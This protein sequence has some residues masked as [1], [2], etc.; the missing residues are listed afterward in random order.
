MARRKAKGAFGATAGTVPQTESI[1][2]SFTYNYESPEDW[3]AQLNSI[4]SPFP[5]V[6]REYD[7]RGMPTDW[8]YKTAIF[9]PNGEELPE[10]ARGWQFNGKPDFGPGLKGIWA[11]ISY[12]FTEDRTELPDDNPALKASLGQVKDVYDYWDTEAEAGN[13]TAGK[14]YGQSFMALL[15][16]AAEGIRAGWEGAESVGGDKLSV[17]NVIPRA[18]GSFVSFIGLGAQE[19]DRWW[20]VDVTGPAY[21]NSIASLQQDKLVTDEEL[22]R[23][24][25]YVGP[26]KAFPVFFKEAIHQ[27][28]GAT[29]LDEVTKDRNEL[30]SELGYTAWKDIAVKEEFL[31]RVAAGEDP[32]LLAMELEDP[33]EEL[34]GEFLFDPLNLISLGAKKLL[35]LAADLGAFGDGVK[36]ARDGKRLMRAIDVAAEGGDVGKIQKATAELLQWIND[37]ARRAVDD[38]AGDARRAEDLGGLR[39]LLTETADSLQNTLTENMSDTIHQLVSLTEGPD[40]AVR[41]MN[42]LSK[43]LD[44]NLEDVARLEALEN[45]QNAIKGTNIPKNLLFGENAQRTA[46]VWRRLMGDNN[47]KRIVELLDEAGGDIVKTNQLLADELKRITNDIFPTIGRRIEEHGKYTE[48][49]KSGKAEDVAKANKILETKPWAANAPNQLHQTLHQIYSKVRPAYRAAGKA[50]GTLFMGLNPA[51]RMRNR[52]GNFAVLFVDVSPK[53]AAESFFENPWS[54]KWAR[55]TLNDYLGGFAP[56]AERR[57]IGGGAAASFDAGDWMKGKFNYFATKASEDE[58]IAGTHVMARSVKRFMNRFL[59]PKY[60]LQGLDQLVKNPGDVKVLQRLIKKHYGDVNKALVEFA[61]A[62]GVDNL[63]N[64]L[65][66]NDRQLAILEKLHLDDAVRK[67]L[68]PSLSRQEQATR[69]NEIVNQHQGRGFLA[70]GEGVIRRDPRYIEEIADIEKGMGG[71]RGNRLGDLFERKV[72]TAQVMVDEASAALDDTLRMVGDAVHNH[73]TRGARSVDEAKSMG[74]KAKDFMFNVIQESKKKADSVMAGETGVRRTMLNFRTQVW[75]WNDEVTEMQ[76][77]SILDL[78][79]KQRGWMGPVPEFAEELPKADLNRM[80]KNS[81]WRG[82]TEKATREYWE[83]F[84]GQMNHYMDGIE[85]FKHVLDPEGTG[86]ISKL[87]EPMLERVRRKHSLADAMHRTVMDGN[88][89]AILRVG[90]N[91]L[92]DLLIDTW[93]IRKAASKALEPEGLEA[94][95]ETVRRFIHNIRTQAQ[96]GTFDPKE[97]MGLL[98]DVLGEAIKD[99]A[100]SEARAEEMLR[101]LAGKEPD[102][103]LTIRLLEEEKTTIFLGGQT[104]DSIKFQMRELQTE[105]NMLNNPAG[106]WGE[107]REGSE[108]LVTGFGDKPLRVSVD[109]LPYT[110][111][112]GQDKIYVNTPLGRRSVKR[113]QISIPDDVAENANRYNELSARMNRM[114]KRLKTAPEQLE[115]VRQ[116][117]IAEIDRRI[118]AIQDGLDV[119]QTA[120]RSAIAE[121]YVKVNEADLPQSMQDEFFFTEDIYRID[122]GDGDYALFQP[123]FKTNKGMGWRPGKFVVPEAQRGRGVGTKFMDEMKKLSDEFKL[124]MGIQPDTKDLHRFYD[125]IDGLI[126]DEA[127]GGRRYLYTPRTDPPERFSTPIIA[128]MDDATPT[129]ARSDYATFPQVKKSIDEVLAHLNTLDDSPQLSPHRAAYSNEEWARLREGASGIQEKINEVRT[130]AGQVAVKERD[131]ALHNYGKRYGFDMVAGLIFPYQFWYSRS[132]AKWM[133]RMVQ[134]PAIL[135]HYLQYR[136]FLEKKHAGLPDWWKYQMNTNDLFGLDAENPLYFNLE[137]MINP[138]HGLTN[139]D[140]TD[141]QRRKDWWGGAMEDIQKMGPSVWT[142]FTYGLAAYYSLQGEEEAAA[143]WAGRLLPQSKAIRDITALVDPQ[144][145]GIEIDPAVHLWGGGDPLAFTGSKV[146]VEAYERGRVGRQLGLMVNEGKWTEAEI[147]EAAYRQEGEIWDVARARAIH[148]RASHWGLI[149]GQFMFGVGAKPRPEGDIQIDTMYKEMR[150]LIAHRPDVSE[151]NYA[152]GWNML[153]EAY[154]FLDT[155]LLAKKGGLERDEALAWNV[156]N[157]IPPGMSFEM[158]K[159]ANMDYDTITQ[160]RSNKGDLSE[161]SEAQRLDFMGGVMQLG[162]LLDVPPDATRRD[163]DRASQEYSDMMAHGEKVFGEDIWQKV[164]LYY[165]SFDESNQDAM[166]NF[167]KANPIVQE[168]LDF[169]QMTINGSPSLMTYYGSVEK[170]EK[171]YKGQ[172]YQT[173]EQVFGDNIWDKWSV[174]HELKDM[175]ETKAANKYFKDNPELKGYL[176]MRDEM[177]PIIDQKVLELGD[178]IE[179]RQ[180]PFFRGEENVIDPNVEIQSFNVDEQQRWISDQVMSY[181]QGQSANNRTQADVVDH[182]RAQA[183]SLWPSTK[184]SARR[185]YKIVNSNP[186]GAASMLQEN[187]ELETRVRW[188]FDR[189]LRIALAREGELEASAARYQSEL[190]QMGVQGQSPTAFENLAPGPLKRLL[191]D[192]DGLPPHL[193]ELLGGR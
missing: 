39:G 130:M 124:E 178:T 180:G 190:E 97:T 161:L 11:R 153:R 107:L 30:A 7:D 189:I 116:A 1:K 175:G 147:I 140:F 78:W 42:D 43:L 23:W 123:Q 26:L 185:Y 101:I 172:F 86:E 36:V 99:V 2:A 120:I 88:G 184:Q 117:E 8:D 41:L 76:H 56:A 160:F 37:G 92:E 81:L 108:V 4:N 174:Y 173:V 12:K 129:V 24:R 89:N 45:V 94:T 57:G 90:A 186:N 47:G 176:V 162:A 106:D 114:E 142:P 100:G 16:I 154:P 29:S 83:G 64:L 146:G 38:I 128:A 163:W 15:G 192:P 68:N 170:L 112:G 111:P 159:V 5:G 65:F 72:H 95:A 165:A 61:D 74:R 145:L 77:I 188:E 20:K 10:T 141:P 19:L 62:R 118:K 133:K 179:E 53:A 13:A 115:E 85:K 157:R 66:L 138:L 58:V 181:A 48:L 110:T 63:S 55:N 187:A 151:E 168:A 9:G 46:H 119:E 67:A 125:Q 96:D 126:I 148:D 166:R 109:S 121:R 183:D 122:L 14:K 31:R 113:S 191:N 150:N 44:S 105:I 17:L 136:R 177:L 137:A 98:D 35:P 103:A 71:I 134:T 135:T 164:D 79:H 91:E 82:Y 40:D 158:A 22:E 25:G 28:T 21:L 143:R 32:R 93:M 75:K 104:R 51:Y 59:T 54:R 18:V 52:M 127:E 69:L 27:I 70:S 84:L 60:A 149:A 156:L 193:W 131:F 144:G 34:M 87:I 6:A 155:I 73:F 102:S 182:I 80:F 171:F 132:Y 167:L 152:K 50:Q 33:L 49:L 3:R 139:V 169:K